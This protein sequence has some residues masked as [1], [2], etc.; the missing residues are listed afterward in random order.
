[1]SAVLLAVDRRVAVINGKSLQL[2][3]RL[4]GYQLIEIFPDRVLLQKNKTKVLLRRSGT[5]QMKD[6]Q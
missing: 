2:G 6:V 4:E 3:D 5:G 1:L